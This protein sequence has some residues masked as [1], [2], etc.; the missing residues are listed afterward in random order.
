MVEGFL[1][2][3]SLKLAV[4][5]DHMSGEMGLLSRLVGTQGTS[6]TWLVTAVVLLVPTQAWLV[7]VGSSATVAAKP[8][9]W[10]EK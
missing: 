10:T 2:E 8:L 5:D 7:L 4:F 1:S 9:S 6:E 3:G